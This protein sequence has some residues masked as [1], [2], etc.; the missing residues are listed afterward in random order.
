M[1][2]VLEIAGDSVGVCK[3][4]IPYKNKKDEVQN[5]KKPCCDDPK[6]KGYPEE[7]PVT[8]ICLN[9]GEWRWQD[10]HLLTD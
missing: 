7:Y 8:Q 5:M 9:C 2:S 1:A 10:A 3:D 6:L 4:Y